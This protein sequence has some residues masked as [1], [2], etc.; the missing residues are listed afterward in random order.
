MSERGP[1][2]E[3][4]AQRNI[5]FTMTDQHAAEAMRCR[6]GASRLSNDTGRT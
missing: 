1:V 3:E 5:L 2:A 4:I 6:T